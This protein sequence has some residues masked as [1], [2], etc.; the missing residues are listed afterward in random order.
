MKKLI[1][2]ALALLITVFSPLLCAFAEDDSGYDFTD[3]TDDQLIDLYQQLQNEMIKRNIL[4]HNDSSLPTITPIPTFSSDT[5]RISGNTITVRDDGS[6]ENTNES[7]I[8]K[9]VILTNRNI[10]YTGTC[11]SFV[12]E[13]YSMQVSEVCATGSSAAMLSLSDGQK[14]TLVTFKMR[15]ENT[16]DEDLSWYPYMSTIIT[17]G[18]EQVSADW[19]LSDSVGGDFYGR[20]V[21]DGQIFFVCKN[22]DA[23]QLTHIQWR[24]EAP[25][26]KDFDRVG[27]DIIIE[28]DLP[29]N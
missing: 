14:A 2:L 13:L 4:P 6:G 8:T 9:R 19:F 17:S 18:K 23:E 3:W 28:L 1:V 11:G 7:D 21:K 22:T 25:H 12:F 29:K 15:V 16:S 24:I 26:N 20:V 5:V 27:D 10:G